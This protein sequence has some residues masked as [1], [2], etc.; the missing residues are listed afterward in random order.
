M[1]YLLFGKSNLV[2]SASIPNRSL[3]VEASAS[4]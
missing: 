4:K 3:T 1:D 2:V